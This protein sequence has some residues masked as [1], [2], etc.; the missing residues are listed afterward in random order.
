MKRVE[1]VI[2]TLGRDA[3]N[4][5]VINTTRGTKA[6]F[7]YR[8]TE[9]LE[10][11][12]A[13]NCEIANDKCIVSLENSVVKEPLE[14]LTNVI[15]SRLFTVMEIDDITMLP[16]VY[17]KD[18]DK[19][20]I[21][22]SRK[23]YDIPMTPNIE[24]KKLQNTLANLCHSYNR[25]KTIDIHSELI[26]RLSL[27]QH[28]ITEL[29]QSFEYK[30]IED[31]PKDFKYLDYEYNVDKSDNLGDIILFELWRVNDKGEFGSCTISSPIT[32]LKVETT[33]ENHTIE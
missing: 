23:M 6:Q 22:T 1:K 2:E 32:N 16:F 17:E 5:I 29:F 13:I 24:L 21:V 33:R 10:Y 12:I 8:L 4:K 31:I 19:V 30:P 15:V 9:G 25:Y 7:T 3:I 14:I 18:N 20:I 11:M 26:N 27:V 28:K